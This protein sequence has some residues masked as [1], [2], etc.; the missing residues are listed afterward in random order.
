MRKLG[1]R[2]HAHMLCVRFASLQPL[3][4]NILKLHVQHLKA[5]EHHAPVPAMRRASLLQIE[6][7]LSVYYIMS[8]NDLLPFWLKYPGAVK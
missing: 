8:Q 6:P 3:T 1:V 4:Y 7:K 5:V 2:M